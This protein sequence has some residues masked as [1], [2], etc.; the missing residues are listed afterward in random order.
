LKELCAIRSRT[1]AKTLLFGVDHDHQ[2]APPRHQFGEPHREII[3]Q[4]PCHRPHGLGEVGDHCRVDRVGLGQPANSPGELTHL[5]R[6]DDGD[7]QPGFGE[8]GGNHA[9]IAATRLEHHQTGRQRLQSRDQCAQTF[10]VGGA[11][12]R[13]ALRSD[14]HID[15]RL[16]YVNANKAIGPGLDIHHPASSMRA[17]AQTTVRVNGMPAGATRSLTAST[18]RTH[19]G[20]R[21]GSVSQRSST[22]HAMPR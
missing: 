18:T 10:R 4:W 7:R 21:P 6:I 22:N 11:A 15:P 20:Y 8:R 2:L 9:F 16:R 13:R 14:M 12:K 1:F 19:S 5:A 3:G 17:R